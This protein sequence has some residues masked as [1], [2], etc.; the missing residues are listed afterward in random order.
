MRQAGYIESEPLG[1]A[2]GENIGWGTLSLSTPG[3]MVGAWM[4]SPD[5]RANIL[6]PRFR[7]TGVGVSPQAPQALSAG[8]SGG[9]YTQDF[10]VIVV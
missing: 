6:D 5:H 8:A 4:A 1:Y 2:I 7:D 10:G 3:A 9:T